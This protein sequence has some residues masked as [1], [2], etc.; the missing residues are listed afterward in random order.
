MTD[1][2][3]LIYFVLLLAIVSLA[4]TLTS[5]APATL[6]PSTPMSTITP[7]S[8]L[9]PPTLQAESVPPPAG[10]TQP[11]TGVSASPSGVALVDTNRMMNDINTLVSFQSRHILSSPSTDTGIQAAQSF[12]I[13]RFQEI[14]S[15]SPYPYLQIDVYPQTFE[16]KWAEKTI[17]PSNVVMAVQ[18]TDASAGVV[19]V[20]AHYDTALQDW[21]NGDG[22]QPGANDNGSGV[23]A[24]LE[25][26]RIMTQTPQRATLLFVLFAAEETGRQGSLAFVN[27]FIRPQNI[28]LMGA[29]N[30]DLI[31]SVTGRRGERYDNV[32][33]VFSEGPNTSAS[34]QLARLIYV[35]GGRQV[36]DIGV[37]VQDRVERAGRW[38][39]HMSFSDSGYPA[40]RLMEMADDTLIVHTQRDTIDTVDPSYLRRT[41]QVTL[42]SLEMLASGPNPPTLRPLIPSPT[43]PNTMTLEWSHNP[44]CVNY[45]VALRR[46]DSLVYNDFY[47]ID[48]TSL[49]WGNFR[50]YE[51][52]TVAC[53]DEKGL[54]GRFAPELLIPSN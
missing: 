40:V 36:P 19:M 22:Y 53:I 1:M 37:E 6:A 18:G 39:D 32:M 8:G 4:C 45:V 54:L 5:Q 31:G 3:R 44:V 34:R 50:A 21:Y 14:R 33:R 29:L 43:D 17:Y 26:A 12:L 15:N 35:A 24:V 49:S 11:Q 13:N 9:I 7:D 41:T 28:P 48:S 46:A 23:A 42:A 10:V 38:G 16:M 27:E 25:I 52:V 2:K 51:A 30:L 20:M 47:T